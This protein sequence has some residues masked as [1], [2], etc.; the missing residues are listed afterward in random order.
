MAISIA[1]A[2][3]VSTRVYDPK[4]KQQVYDSTDFLKY[5]KD[6]E[7]IVIAGGNDLSW[8]VRYK[9]LGT[10]NDV[11][12]DDQVVFQAIETRTSAVDDWAPY[13]A[14]TM[15]TWEERSKNQSGKQQIVN[16]MRDK[17]SEL[18][19]DMAWRL[20]TDIFATS[21]ATG[22]L[23]P[24]STIIDSAATYAGIAVA[25]AS[26][27]AAVEDSSSTTLTRALLYTNIASAT[28]GMNKPNRHYTTRALLAAY[29]GLLGSDER[30]TNTKEANAG[31]TNITLYGDPVFGEAFV[32][33]NYWYG[34]DMDS[35]ELWVQKG[36]DM[37]I[38]DWE[39]LFVAGYPDSFGKVC[40]SVCNLVCRR[41]KTNFKL[42]A[43]TGT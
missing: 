13:R 2:N 25:D 7:K 42:S 5:M 12:W 19:E 40:M 20:N 6:N 31:F 11:G 34:L 4:I 43:L 36:N 26:D 33:T 9:K 21:A 37:K 35:L 17:S 23:T 24:L 41:R 32:P 10:A 3:A 27:W 14:E 28:F 8:P 18:G 29:N 15:L 38:S 22:K 30:Y 39:N 16:L 1:Q